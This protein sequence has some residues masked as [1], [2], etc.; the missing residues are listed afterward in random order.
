MRDSL[1]IGAAPGFIVP[2]WK[3]STRTKTEDC[4]GVQESRW[5][6]S[7]R[8]RQTPAVRRNRRRPGARMMRG[9]GFFPGAWKNHPDTPDGSRAA[10]EGSAGLRVIITPLWHSSRLSVK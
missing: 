7:W 2:A 5:G 4:A 9:E 3:R 6:S 1:L 10:D 8:K